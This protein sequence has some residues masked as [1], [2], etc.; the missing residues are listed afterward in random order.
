MSDVARELALARLRQEHPDWSPSQ[1]SRE[2]LRLSF[3]PDPL[4]QPLR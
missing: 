1:L 4:P 2:L 3:L